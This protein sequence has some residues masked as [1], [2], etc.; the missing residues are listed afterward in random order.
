MRVITIVADILYSFKYEFERDWCLTSEPNDDEEYD[1]IK[2]MFLKK[3]DEVIAFA[4]EEIF[5]SVNNTIYFSKYINYQ[6][7]DVYKHRFSY[8]KA[9][10]KEKTTENLRIVPK[11][12]GERGYA[13]YSHSTKELLVICSKGNL[14]IPFTTSVFVQSMLLQVEVIHTEPK[15][16]VFVEVLK[17]RNTCDYSHDYHNIT[18]DIATEYFFFK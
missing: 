10:W 2:S 7:F 17:V 12:D 11:W 6:I 5:N 3:V 9:G 16:I 1:K 18:H 15:A 8:A 14:S 13:L 4:R